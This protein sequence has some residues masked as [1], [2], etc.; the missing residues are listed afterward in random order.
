MSTGSLRVDA[1]ALDGGR[2]GVEVRASWS[3]RPQEEVAA[4]GAAATESVGVGDV[5]GAHWLSMKEDFKATEERLEDAGAIIE[6]YG[7]PANLSTSRLFL[8]M[9]LCFLSCASA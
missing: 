1:K 8:L 5:G 4:A 9:L 7:N 3:L 2:G 6:A